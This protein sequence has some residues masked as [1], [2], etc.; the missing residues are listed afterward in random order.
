[1]INIYIMFYILVYGFYLGNI[2]DFALGIILICTLR[3]RFCSYYSADFTT[4]VWEHCFPCFSL[5]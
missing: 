5:E 4:T 2:Y 3:Y 1:M